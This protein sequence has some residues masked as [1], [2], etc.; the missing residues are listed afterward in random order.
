MIAATAHDEI[1]LR[2]IQTVLQESLVS[3]TANKA[4]LIQSLKDAGVANAEQIVEFAPSGNNLVLWITVLTLLLTLIQTLYQTPK[5]I[6]DLSEA[7][8]E[9]TQTYPQLR[10]MID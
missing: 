10:G 9:I 7:F 2:R 8:Q 6:H 1:L 5:G 3:G 4:S